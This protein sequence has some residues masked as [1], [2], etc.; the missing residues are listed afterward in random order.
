VPQP[1]S[2][3]AAPFVSRE[4][5]GEVLLEELSDLRSAQVL[6]RQLNDCV[7]GLRELTGTRAGEAQAHLKQLAAARFAQAP[8]LGSLLLRWAGRLKSDVDVP[9]LIAHF[10]R[11]ALVS[12]TMGALRRAAERLPRGGRS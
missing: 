5:N 7:Q 10:E 2:Q 9:L 6:Q 12:A 3:P 1:R 11:L 4:V 8:A